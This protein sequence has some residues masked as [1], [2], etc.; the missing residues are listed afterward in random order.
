MT[1]VGDEATG[2]S[3]SLVG[4]LDIELESTAG[5]VL[6]VT[7]VLQIMVGSIPWPDVPVADV[8]VVD[9]VS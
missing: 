6:T 8:S 2:E 1:P 4:E 3:G 9:V 7:G 5:E